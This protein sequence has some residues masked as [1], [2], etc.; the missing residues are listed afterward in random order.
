[1]LHRHGQLV[2]AEQ[3]YQNILNTAP[4][5]FDAQHLLGVLKHLRGQNAEALALISAALRQKPKD[6]VALSNYGVVLN[7]LTRFAEALAS[8]DQAIIL[9]PNYAEALY[10]RGIAL[11]GLKRFDEALA[12]YDKAISLKPDNAGAFNNRGNALKE[13]KRLDEA[14]ASYDKAIALKPNYAEAL[15]NRGVALHELKR[16]DEALANYDQAIALK[17]DNVAAFNNRGNVLKELKR[18]DET[19]ASYDKAIVLKPDDAE[20]FNNRS[21]TLMELGRL[22]EARQA[23]E[24]AIQLA[25]R[26]ARYYRTLGD[27]GR[28]AANDPRIAVMET[29]AQD[30]ASLSIEDQIELHFALGKAYEDLDRHAD[31]FRQWL[32]GNAL[33]RRRIAYDE[34]ATLGM[35]RRIRNMFTPELIRTRQYVGDPSQLP[36]FIIGM[37]RSGTTLVEQILAS[38]PQVFGG[39][40]LAHFGRAAN[41]RTILGGSATSPASLSAMTG[42]DF[43]EIGSRYLAEIE[44]LAPDADRITN[45]MIGNFMLAGLI[46]LALP[47]AAIIHTIRDPV[48]TCISCFSK[49]FG[50]FNYTYD[51]AELGRYYMNYQA[52]MEHWHGILPPGRILDV[53]YEDVVA[54]LEG[55]AR[56]IISHCGL[57]WDPHCLAFHQTER[58][59]STYSANQVRQPIYKSAVG[60]WRAYEQFLDPILMG[61]VSRKHQ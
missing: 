9:K 53:R 46:H 7:V 51:L 5:H 45:K 14:L 29:L 50:E 43:H 26:T 60:R 41:T 24:Q 54:D 35:L 18:F 52:V 39:G 28:Y 22:T 48:D 25:P 49:L 59:V 13:L 61:L 55:Q 38:H 32:T 57:V 58:P 20:A 23:A 16:F 33:K 36:V 44:Q 40:E 19:L 42:E 27:L 56:R 8:L 21:I 3:I 31:A 1:M 12:S 34:A 6:F 11:Q 37:P 30:A 4:D 15:Y 47:N 10:N 17:P 2:A